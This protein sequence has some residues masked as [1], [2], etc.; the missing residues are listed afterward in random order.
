M[1]LKDAVKR[2]F[3]LRKQYPNYVVDIDRYLSTDS[4]NESTNPYEEALF[5]V[6]R[7]TGTD[8]LT[9]QTLNEAQV[10]KI[11]D[12]D[13]VIDVGQQYA[14]AKNA[15]Q[16]AVRQEL[17]TLGKS[18]PKEK[19]KDNFELTKGN[20]K[21]LNEL[22]K[23]TLFR[24]VGDIDAYKT[25]KTQIKIIREHKKFYPNNPKFDEE[26]K[27]LEEIIEIFENALKNPVE[28]GKGIKSSDEYREK[29]R[30]MSDTI[31]ALSEEITGYKPSSLMKLYHEL[32]GYMPVYDESYI[33]DFP[34]MFG[35]FYD[36]FDPSI[37]DP[38]EKFTNL[39]YYISSLTGLDT[40][41]IYNMTEYKIKKAL[42]AND[43][44]L[45][46][47]REALEKEKELTILEKKAISSSAYGTTAS[48]VAVAHYG[49]DRKKAAA[50]IMASQAQTVIALAIS[51]AN[52]MSA[53]DYIDDIVQQGMLFCNLKVDDYL[54]FCKDNPDR[55]ISFPAYI[56][57]GLGLYLKKYAAGL[58]KGG[59]MGDSTAMNLSTL[60]N[61]EYQKFRNNTMVLNPESAVWSEEEWK[62]A[63]AMFK[64]KNGETPLFGGN[65]TTIVRA[66]E[67][68]EEGK[69]V[70]QLKS[71]YDTEQMYE[72]NRAK[73]A[74]DSA[75]RDY[76]DILDTKTESGLRIFAAADALVLDRLMGFVENKNNPQSKW[77]WTFRE[78]GK[79]I[80]VPDSTVNVK[81]SGPAN[82]FK[83]LEE[84]AKSNPKLKKSV[85]ILT[86]YLRYL[87]SKE[88][89][90]LRGVFY[91]LEHLTELMVKEV[92][93]F[94]TNIVRAGKEGGGRYYYEDEL[95]ERL[96]ENNGNYGKPYSYTNFIT[97]ETK[98]F[99]P[100]K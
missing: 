65:S 32:K 43:F 83:K 45:I 79:D 59:V 60:D 99:Q 34:K 19:E 71:D 55:H 35:K 12:F 13:D 36:V 11:I 58:K 67:E 48:D 87:Y 30:A 84:A 5:F 90:Q 46:E 52:T 47:K 88:N 76:M 93:E 100:K 16:S 85:K 97:K 81:F 2:M 33:S 57:T 75:C 38:I 69:K 26:L 64:L 70:F 24:L 15:Y 63:F 21:F 61:R 50:L 74:L 39:L 31:K 53:Q 29:S 94:E 56:G 8:P 40:F 18:A 22:S 9:L 14:E 23:K 66:D 20:V 17:K 10:M 49:N 4:L 28:V 6:S 27:N 41:E 62:T 37:T 96:E 92:R 72:D 25:A 42:I 51:I 98:I 7:E 80:N 1:E 77:F 3:G 68:D 89:K 78:I 82:I 54:D 44:K 73:N 91:L 95:L 86:N